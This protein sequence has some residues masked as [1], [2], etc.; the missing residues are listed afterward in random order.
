[1]PGDEPTPLQRLSDLRRTGPADAT[2]QNLLTVLAAKLDFCS[3]L[4]IY[5][6]EAETDGH[7]LCARA[8]RKLAASEMQ[9]FEELL[10][11]LREHLAES[12][13]QTRERRSS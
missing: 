5:E 7:R 1:V 13:N 2:L 11:S 10:A 3:R 9:A 6:Y 12:G 4:P 8:F